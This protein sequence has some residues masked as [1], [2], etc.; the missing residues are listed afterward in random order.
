MGGLGGGGC[1]VNEYIYHDVVFDRPFLYFLTAGSRECV[2]PLFAGIVTKLENVEEETGMIE[3]ITGKINIRSKPSKS[4][5]KVGTFAKGE[6]YEYFEKQVNE[7]YTWYRIG[8]NKWV[9]DEGGKWIKEVS[10][11]DVSKTNKIENIIGKINIRSKPS[12]SSDKVGTFAKGEV[13][14][15]FEMQVNEGYTWY[16]IGENK[17]VADEGGKWIKEINSISMKKQIE[18]ITGKINIRSKPSKSGEKVGTFAKG[19]VYEYFETQE[20]EGYTWYRIGENKW[21]ADQN[22]EWIKVLDS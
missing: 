19:E 5:E 15:Y 20:N 13:Y 3:N 22:G 10:A 16:R 4:G 18:N 17:W 11:S 2:L 1:D 9:A 21:V 6:V 14:E 12:K 7:G 8:E